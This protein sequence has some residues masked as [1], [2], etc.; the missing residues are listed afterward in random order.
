V[1]AAAL[2]ATSAMAAG[3]I[4]PAIMQ[5]RP[6][7][8]VCLDQADPEGTLRAGFAS[9]WHGRTMAA[10][11]NWR[12]QIESSDFGEGRPILW[13][14]DPRSWV[15]YRNGPAGTAPP[16][17]F[18]V[19]W[20]HDPDALRRIH[21]APARIVPC[22]DTP[23]WIYPASWDPLDQLISMADALVPQALAVGRR[24]CLP[25][26]RSGADPRELPV[27]PG[28]WRINLHYDLGTGAPVAWR[29]GTAAIALTP[30]DGI[31]GVVINGPA[32]LMLDD[33]TPTPSGQA[34]KVRG[35]SIAPSNFRAEPHTAASPPACGFETASGGG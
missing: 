19:L 23:I 12:R 11:S 8:L 1:A 25:P 31:A 26:H 18:I 16:F 32:R 14:D 34:L 29:V 30:G 10:A 33:F 20:H 15:R 35:Y 27:P 5:W 9:F 7:A 22:G 13:T 3:S 24:V 28:Q 4:S 21:G 6:K 2:V 17:R